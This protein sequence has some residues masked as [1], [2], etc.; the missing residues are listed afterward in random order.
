MLASASR[1]SLS[2][3]RRGK[4]G[5]GRK[6]GQREGGWMETGCCNERQARLA[7]NGSR[8][9]SRRVLARLF[10]TAG[11]LRWERS[12]HFDQAFA[13]NAFD[14]PVLFLYTY[15]SGWL[16]PQRSEAE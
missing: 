1:L 3:K 10:Y 6:N 7:R 8:L 11:L 5:Q 14:S 12:R 15:A 9:Y 13:Y 2:L 4:E 16:C